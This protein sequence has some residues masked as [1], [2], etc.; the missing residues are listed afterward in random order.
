[1]MTCSDD[2]LQDLQLCA[3]KATSPPPTKNIQFENTFTCVSGQIPITMN[4]GYEVIERIKM[5]LLH[6][7]QVADETMDPQPT[8]LPHLHGVG[9]SQ[10]Q[11]NTINSNT[12]GQPHT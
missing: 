7:T 6:R 3:E 8:L 11:S 9:T 12:K 10:I 2:P 4:T 1:M 5:L